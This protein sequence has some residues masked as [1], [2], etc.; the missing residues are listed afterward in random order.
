M[1][2]EKTLWSDM[3][4]PNGFKKNS[5]FQKTLNPNIE[6]ANWTIKVGIDEKSNRA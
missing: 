6:N 2:L 1:H 3:L 5:S 4:K